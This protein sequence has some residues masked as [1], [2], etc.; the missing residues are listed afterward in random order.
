M[1]NEVF[2]DWEAA[3]GNEADTDEDECTTH[4]EKTS[5]PEARITEEDD[6]ETVLATVD[7]VCYFLNTTCLFV[8]L[9]L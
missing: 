2:Q 7:D 5:H 4:P 8:Y 6:Q 3:F 1:Y 9:G